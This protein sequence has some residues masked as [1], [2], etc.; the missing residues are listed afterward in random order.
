[1]QLRIHLVILLITHC[2]ISL[3][4]QDVDIDSNYKNYRASTRASL[5][6]WSAEQIDLGLVRTICKPF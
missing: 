4:V 6:A 1:M 3:F 5:E 2:N